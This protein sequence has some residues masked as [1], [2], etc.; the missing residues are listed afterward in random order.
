MF[1]PGQWFLSWQNSGSCSLKLRGGAHFVRHSDYLP[2]SHPVFISQHWQRLPLTRDPENGS[3]CLF[4]WLQQLS[5]GIDRG[6][7]VKMHRREVSGMAF[8]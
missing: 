2:Y 7:P 3:L 6:K 4:Q 5:V 1:D 8:F